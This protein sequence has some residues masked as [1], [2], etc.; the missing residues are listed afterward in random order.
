M[1]SVVNADQSEFKTFFLE[2]RTYIVFGPQ[3]GAQLD[4]YLKETDIVSDNSIWPFEE[5]TRDVLHNINFAPVLFPFT[6]DNTTLLAIFYVMKD[7]AQ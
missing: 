3:M 4:M 5:N 2:D 7:A 6:V 1:N